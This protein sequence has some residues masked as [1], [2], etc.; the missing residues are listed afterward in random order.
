MISPIQRPW[1]PHEHPGWKDYTL[2]FLQKLKRDVLLRK[3][4]ISHNS[5]MAELFAKN[6]LSFK[7]KCEQMAVYFIDSFFYY[8][9]FQFCRAYL[10]GWP[11]EQGSESDA[12]EATARTLPL[13]AA[14]LHYQMTNQGKLDSYGKCVRQALKQAFICGT[15]P[16]HPGYWGKI[17]DYDQRI[18][19]CC[20]I[21][22]ALWL[23]RNTVWKS[24]SASEQERILCW[25]QGVNNC[26]T[27]DNNW[28]LFIVLTQQVV[29][30]LSGKGENSE[31]RYARVKEFYV[32]EGW[33]RDGANG[34]FDYY[35]SWA[36]HYLLF[37]ID[38]INPDFDHQFITQSC[39]EFAKTF[40]YFFTP[41]GFPFFGRSISYRL[42]APV[43]LM[44]NAIQSG[45]ADGQLKRI[46]STLT[47]FFILHGAEQHG[48]ITQGLFQADRRLMDGYSGSGSS[49]WSLRT[50]ILML[51][52]GTECGLWDTDEAPLEIETASFDFTIDAISA[53]VTG[54]KE[55]Q[56][57]IVTFAHDQYPDAPFKDGKLIKQGWWPIVLESVSGRSTRP[58]NNLLRKGVTTFSSRLNLYL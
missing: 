15:D 35:N 3:P 52:S 40:R 10:P 57:V 17:K 55:T 38:R 32:G 33:F 46:I 34:N 45:R 19:E 8:S 25:L 54:I 44:A 5:E 9:R 27:V 28:H 13:M 1:L 16:E 14:W 49:L 37:W 58:K 18:C 36:F 12:I 53:R 4:F 48:V 23:V 41:C 22:L 2:L 50:L 31:Q 7:E 43:A 56:E 26:K 6:H 21:A 47:H 42:A 39:A 20:D 30:A 51:Y 24:Y 29:L 11:S